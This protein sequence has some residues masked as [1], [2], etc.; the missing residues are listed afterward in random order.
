MYNISHF[1]FP[2]SPVVRAKHEEL[3]AAIAA[4]NEHA[5]VSGNPESAAVARKR[6]EH[7]EQFAAIAA[8]HE[9]I[10]EAHRKAAEEEERQRVRTEGGGG[11]RGGVGARIRLN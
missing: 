9:R 11:G 10:A 7:E 2:I 5:A 6:A 4:R 8:E 1:P 3:F